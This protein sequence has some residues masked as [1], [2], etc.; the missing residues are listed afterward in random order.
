VRGSAWGCSPSRPRWRPLGFMFLA[1][2]RPVYSPIGA[3][4][5]R[6]GDQRT[7]EASL[8][9]T[10]ERYHMGTA[11]RSVPQGFRKPSSTRQWCLPHW[12]ICRSRTAAVGTRACVSM[13]ILLRD[14]P[15]EAPHR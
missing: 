14:V 1:L 6:G 4:R 12:Q 2:S 8:Y 11:G 13:Y 15:A 5:L 7:V 3:K 10:D 9:K